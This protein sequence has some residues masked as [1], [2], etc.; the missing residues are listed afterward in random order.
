MK[1]SMLLLCILISTSFSLFGQEDE[2]LIEENSIGE[3]ITSQ[4]QTL[5]DRIL[6][7]NLRIK[8]TTSTSDTTESTLDDENLEL[9]G[10]VINGDITIAENSVYNSSIVVKNGTLRVAGTLRGNALVINGDLI[11]QSTGVI[12]GNVEVMNGRILKDSG[13]TILGYEEISTT[14]TRSPKVFRKR[15]FHTSTQF[16]VPWQADLLDIDQFMFR[17]NRVESIFLG[18]GSEKKYYWDGSRSWNAYGFLGWGFKSHKWRALLGVSRQY[19][20]TTNEKTDRIF[21]V[22][23]EGY[24]LTDTKDRW[25]IS[26]LENTLAALLIHEDFRDYFQREGYTMYIGH[27]TQS[28]ELKTELKL[29][30]KADEYESM[31]NRVDWALFGG[32]K[33]FRYNPPVSDIR[34]RSFVLSGGLTTVTK[35]NDG[36]HGW[37]LFAS[38]EYARRSLGSDVGFDQYLLEICRF[39]PI[40]SYNNINVRLRVGTSDG[41]VPHQR[42]FDLGGIG[43]LNA[44]PTKSFTGNRL[45]LLNSEFILSGGVFDDLN[46]PLGVLKHVILILMSDAGW[47]AH[48]PTHLNPTEGFNTLSFA[49]VQHNLGVAVGNRSGSYRVGVAWRTDCKAPVRFLLRI[50]RPF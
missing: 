14:R 19:R 41:N 7:H 24:S 2:V 4:V 31:E 10:N 40:D 47:I 8:D 22:G 44:F 35:T 12:D 39:Q 26:T 45:V 5:I 46:F 3:A 17:Y 25:Y 9:Q 6:H 18:F 28:D 42:L 37:Q 11:V 33:H 48:V 38:T 23:I 49:N 16:D 29:S 27:Y 1:H 36:S 20:Y 15:L 30:L 13:A 43:T 32:K 50:Q 34:M 21:D